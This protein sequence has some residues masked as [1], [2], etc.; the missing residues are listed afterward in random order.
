MQSWQQAQPDR[1]VP[2]SQTLRTCPDIFQ[3]DVSGGAIHCESLGIQIPLPIAGSSNLVV[4][5]ADP[6]LRI[7]L[8]PTSSESVVGNWEESGLVVVQVRSDLALS[9]EDLRERWVRRQPNEGSGKNYNSGRRDYGYEGGS[10][11]FR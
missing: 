3:V 10:L 2:G 8:S 1:T 6:R 9:G 11:D 4:V 7:L 5:Y